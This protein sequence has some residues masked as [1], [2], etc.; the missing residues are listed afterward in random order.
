MGVLEIAGSVLTGV[1]SGGATGLIGIALQQW[2]D[3]KKRA[4]DLEVI[5][6][7]HLQTKEL[8][9]L[10]NQRDLQMAT[11]SAESAETL[12]NIQA[13]SRVEE[14]N[15]EDYRASIASDRATHL[16]PEAQKHW[17]VIAMMGIVDF[18]RGMIRPGITIYCMV[19]LT[20]LLFWVRDM[21]QRSQIELTA[22]D[23]RKLMMEVI[24]TT[25]YL[26]VTTVVWWFGR[27]PEAPPKR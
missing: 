23:S 21:W 13:M 19:L 10:D 4:H 16:S 15:S 7:Q 5:K 26:V 6:Q 14:M 9:E 12:A 25:T 2:G 3:I 24:T 17:F 11:V 20:M 1:M 22:D 18:F 8:K 27:R